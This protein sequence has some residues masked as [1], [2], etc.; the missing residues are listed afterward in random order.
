MGVQLLCDLD[1]TWSTDLS[2][3]NNGDVATVVGA[4]RGQQRILRRLMTNPG[5][6]IFQP[7]YGAG[8]PQY[9]GQNQSKATLDLISG[10]ITGQ[11]LM[12]AVVAADP[13][14]VVTLQQMPD[15]SLDVNIQYTD[16]P[17]GNPVVLSFNVGND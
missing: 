1:Q 4:L 15:F 17:T 14:P 6:Y 7:D 10:T 12:E 9:V 2:A 5:D 13:A 11:I 8:V 16:A 3:S